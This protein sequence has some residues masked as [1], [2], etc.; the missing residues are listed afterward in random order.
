VAAAG[1]VATTGV[2]GTFGGITTTDGGRYC[3]ATEAGVTI[4]GAGAGVSITGF[5]GGTAF[6]SAGVARTSTFASTA[7]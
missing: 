3:A 4:L 7:G 5:G 2:G 6:G 1:G